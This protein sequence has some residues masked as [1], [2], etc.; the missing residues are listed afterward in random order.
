MGTSFAPARI[1]PQKLPPDSQAGPGASAGGMCSY[2]GEV[3]ANF[4]THR[5][6]GGESNMQVHETP[7]EHGG[8]T[9]NPLRPV[10]PPQM[11]TGSRQEHAD[12]VCSTLDHSMAT[13][14]NFPNPSDANPP[15]KHANMRS[16][17]WHTHGHEHAPDACAPPWTCPL[18]ARQQHRHAC[19]KREH[20]EVQL[21]V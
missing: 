12:R 20:G 18:T 10:A 11:H 21:E 19:G 17:A 14:M 6:E 9:S 4:G 8:D 16:L 2:P 3:R 7:R 5:M 13:G 15:Q 1:A